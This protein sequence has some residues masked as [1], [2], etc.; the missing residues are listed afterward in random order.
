MGYVWMYGVALMRKHDQKQ[1]LEL[2]KTLNEAQAEIKRRLSRKDIPS[3]IQLLSDCQN[4]AAR[5]G[6]FIEEIEGSGTHTVV[7]LEEFCE[8]LYQASTAI[9]N[10]GHEAGLVKKLKKQIAAIENSVRDELKPN[11]IEV[12]FIPYKAAMWDALESIW[13]AAQADP[14]CDAYVM[15][16]PYFDRLP[17]GA[18]GQMRYEGGLYPDY[19]PVVDWQNYSV[20]ARRPDVV[21]THN[22]YDDGN[23]VTSIHP[24]FYSKRLK[25][26]TD[27][28]VY[29]PYF[30]SVEENVPEHFC[31]C[32]GTLYADRVILQSE[33]IREV[34]IRVFKAFEEKNHCINRFGKAA[35]KFLALGS[36]K[37]D[38]V[39]NTRQED[40][41]IPEIW[42]RL[43]EKPDG[44][45]K[46]VIL[47]NTS[48]GA[49][50]E[51]N[52]RMLKKLGD[53]FDRFRNRDDVVLL[54]RPHP[55]NE[56]AYQ[57]MRPQLLRDYE[58][59]VAEYQQEGFG[60][61][62]DTADL[63]RAIEISDIYYGDRSSLATLYGIIGKPVMIQNPDIISE[64]TYFDSLIF[65]AF[66]DSGDHFFFSA[67]LFNGL[68]EM[69]K[70]AWIP[71]F[72][73]GFPELKAEGK[74]L[75]YDAVSVQ[76]KLYFAP[77]TSHYM[78]ECDYSG[79]KRAIYLR[80]NT[81]DFKIKNFEYSFAAI[82]KD[83]HNIY[84]LP[85]Y[86]PA[87]VKYDT[88]SDT[89]EYYNDWV[90]QV[91]ALDRTLKFGFFLKG[92]VVGNELIAPSANGGVVVVVNLRN[93]LSTVIKVGDKE[94]HYCSICFDGEH[95]WLG[96]Y[97]GKILKWRREAN[98]M[99]EVVSAKGD[100]ALLYWWN[101]IHLE[102]FVWAF[103]YYS[104]NILKI[105]V[106]DNKV[107]D[108]EI[109]DKFKANPTELPYDYA[110]LYIAATAIKGKIYA[111]TGQSNVFIEF[112]PKSGK[113]RMEPIVLSEEEHKKIKQCHIKG[114]A[115]DV[116]TDC[117]Y[118]SS[119]LKL[120]DM[121]TL[122]GTLYPAIKS[123]TYA[124]GHC[125]SA[126]LE[127]VKKD[128]L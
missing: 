10:T 18:F 78:A 112:D 3:V 68:F 115:N 17:G 117:Y 41:V 110:R 92:I 37:F 45:R 35:E 9:A 31:V 81:F 28:L 55:L 70:K 63:H 101:L 99:Q 48:I 113:Q 109:W 96:E 76:S 26:F 64:N 14:Q 2:L 22:P 53:V 30:V 121:F 106:A 72:L 67:Q 119:L 16:I 12:L 93:G 51:S 114:I 88:A 20:E 46:K 97:S 23:Y 62:D 54:W 127:M 104:G 50:L 118:E 44:T 60:V 4:G 21:F 40:C 79:F 122:L 82:L 65:N 126:V 111:H 24:D 7:L 103:P 42:R 123:N 116:S 27:L 108:A 8:S 80:E 6:G 38:R 66:C 95:Y 57:A 107:A 125:G 94:N 52:E 25:D 69:D 58:R 86:Y 36:P 100:P 32:A 39:I 124:D 102:G 47:Y 120:E 90:D 5:L 89:L 91:Y 87:I 13:L 34:Y 105:R 1:I 19:V 75:F 74:G 33:Q 56:A 73:G 85:T 98:E 49:L 15:P 11:K 59:I 61:F 29:V 71:R 77:M 128:I 83:G 43:I 84:L